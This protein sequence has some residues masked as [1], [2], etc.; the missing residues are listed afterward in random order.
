MDIAAD[1]RISLVQTENGLILG[2]PAKHVRKIY[3]HVREKLLD[4]N[5][6]PRTAD[7]DP[8]FPSLSA[9]L[10]LI[11]GDLPIIYQLRREWIRQNQVKLVAEF[12]LIQLILS[13]HLKSISCWSHRYVCFVNLVG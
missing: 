5:G 9:C 1:M 7:F 2:I 12:D 8:V 13:K 3:L 6:L 11:Q 10:L 4:A